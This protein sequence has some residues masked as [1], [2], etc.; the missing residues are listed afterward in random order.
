MNG[1]AWAC[2]GVR[3]RWITTRIGGAGAEGLEKCF[4]CGHVA[5]RLVHLLEAVAPTAMQVHVG[6]FQFSNSSSY[7]AIP[8]ARV[9]LGCRLLTDQVRCLGWQVSSGPPGGGWTSSG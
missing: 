1:R 5:R 9:P 8:L 6:S 7:F 2:L 3:V 4:L